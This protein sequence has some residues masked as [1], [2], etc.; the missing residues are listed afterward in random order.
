MERNLYGWAKAAD[1]LKINCTQIPL[2]NKDNLPCYG[3]T[4]ALTIGP[5]LAY[6]DDRDLLLDF[7]G[8][9]MEELIDRDR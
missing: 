4:T 3:L 9:D 5:S 6:D 1:D 7:L 2:Q 8:Y